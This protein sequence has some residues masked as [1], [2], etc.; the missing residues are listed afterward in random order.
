MSKLEFQ[1]GH[2]G[3][4]RWFYLLNV[5][6]TEQRN[7]W[8]FPYSFTKILSNIIDVDIPP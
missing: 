1:K 3:L 6:E 8:D 2:G 5:Q 7:T 4:G